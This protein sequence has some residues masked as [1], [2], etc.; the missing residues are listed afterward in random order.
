MS[1]PV[2]PSPAPQPNGFQPLKVHNASFSLDVY[3]QQS[4]PLQFLRELTVNGIQGIQNL[5]PGA[6]GTIVWD[7]DWERV[8]ASNG[9]ERKL[10]ISDTGCGMTHDEM[11]FY[12]NQL[13]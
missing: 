8:V 7:V 5:G 13:A 10:A 9:R 1:P 3:G 4:H 12:I 6:K 11:A 2:P